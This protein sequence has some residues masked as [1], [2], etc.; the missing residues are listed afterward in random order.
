MTTRITFT[1]ITLP[2][3]ISIK[4]SG[5]TII[6][7]GDKYNPNIKELEEDY[8]VSFCWEIDK[9]SIKW[10]KKKIKKMEQ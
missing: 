10:N 2:T 8:N 7:N 3:K 6:V 5:K 9:T 4:L 1:N